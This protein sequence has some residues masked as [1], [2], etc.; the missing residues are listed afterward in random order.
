MN[1]VTLMYSMKSAPIDLRS[2]QRLYKSSGSS[3]TVA[4]CAQNVI[5]QQ[6]HIPE[7]P[8]FREASALS[9]V[10]TIGEQKHFI[11]TK[12][13]LLC[14]STCTVCERKFERFS[15]SFAHHD[16]PVEKKFK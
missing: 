13:E 9:Y 6:S 8:V 7:R 10:F 3:G 14:S 2:L 1:I 15:L 16:E 12:F 4:F 5:R 11:G